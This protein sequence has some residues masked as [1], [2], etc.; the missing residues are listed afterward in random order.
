MDTLY[1][2]KSVDLCP[3]CGVN[4]AEE[5]HACPYEECVGGNS[6]KFCTCCSAC[7][8]ACADDI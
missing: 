1:T 5:P 4:P 8:K 2:Q 6:G 7:T 3:G